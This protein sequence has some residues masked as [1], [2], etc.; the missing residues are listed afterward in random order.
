MGAVFLWPAYA[1]EAEND[2]KTTLAQAIREALGSNPQILATVSSRKA[3]GFRLKQGQA[4][5]GPVIDVSG[6]TGY[7][8]SDDSSTRVGDGSSTETLYRYEMGLTLTQMLFDGEESYN[9]V[10]RQKALLE[11][12]SHQVR[13]T[14]ELIALA[15]TEAFLEVQRQKSILIFS[16]D[17]V[18]EHLSILSLIQDGVSAGRLTQADLEQVKA[19]LASARAQRANIMQSLNNAAADYQN[20]VGSLPQYL[21]KPVPPLHEISATVELEVEH[22]LSI[23]PSLDISNANVKAAFAQAEG[24]NATFYPSVDMQLNARQGRDLGGVK[25]RDTSASAL[26]VMNWNLFNGGADT[27]RRKELLEEYELSK[28]ELGQARRDLERDVRQSWSARD[29]AASRETQFYRQARANKQVVEAYKDQFNLG[30]RSLLDVLD[31][32]SEHFLTRANAVSA[33]TLKVFTTYQMLALKGRLLPA[34]G[35]EYP[36]GSEFDQSLAWSIKDE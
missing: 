3:S 34:L 25:G 11:S 10:R 23:S 13:E 16:S 29:A 12:A 19:R 7:E 14:S 33:K 30:R 20:L 5:Y 4:R 36:D 35:L 24:A 22:A 27:A 8:R 1:Q 32:Q 9:E 6:D 28:A 2:G 18:A 31:A 15:V 21:G 26:F 17:N